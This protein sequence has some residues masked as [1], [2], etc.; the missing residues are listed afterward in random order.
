M[1]ISI[2]TQ[3]EF[4]KLIEEY[5]SITY[6]LIHP[7]YRMAINHIRKYPTG[8]R[9]LPEDT[10]VYVHLDDNDDVIEFLQ[11]NNLIIHGMSI[12][13]DLTYDINPPRELHIIL[14]DNVTKNRI[15]I[16]GEITHLSI[17]NCPDH[18]IVDLCPNVMKHLGHLHIT[19][20]HHLTINN[21]NS[22]FRGHYLK[23]PHRVYCDLLYKPQTRHLDVSESKDY[24]DT[25]NYDVLLKETR[26]VNYI[27]IKHASYIILKN[28]NV[29]E[30]LVYVK[31][32]IKGQ[33]KRSSFTGKE[34]TKL[35]Y[36]ELSFEDT[37]RSSPIDLQ[38]PQYNNID[39]F[40]LFTDRYHD[41][42]YS[43]ID[44]SQLLNVRIFGCTIGGDFMKIYQTMKDSNRDLTF[45]FRN[46]NI[47]DILKYNNLIR[48]EEFRLN[49]VNLID[50]V[51]SDIK[52][53]NDP[54]VMSNVKLSRLLLNKIYNIISDIRDGDT[55]WMYETR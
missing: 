47:E 18:F 45:E 27:N 30:D 51:G 55:S 10:I 37:S 28:L 32:T 8:W 24:D 23:L 11:N 31:I 19:S 6:G 16:D 36:L 26:Y 43:N 34:L 44:F 15:M 38:L 53:L 20:D 3:D 17:D 42:F 22:E 41:N 35:R 40:R 25:S 54:R 52:Y 39:I 14:K 49:V 12:I 5:L 33:F 29:L 21:L 7:A 1:D 46:S 50:V 4:N 13:T 48:R 2:Y 9:D